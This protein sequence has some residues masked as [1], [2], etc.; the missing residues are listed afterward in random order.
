MATKDAVSCPAA[1]RSDQ[2]GEPLVNAA[3]LG[4]RH[5]DEKRE[6]RE[7]IFLARLRKHKVQRSGA[8]LGAATAEIQLIERAPEFGRH[9][10]KI[11]GSGSKAGTHSGGGPGGNERLTVPR[12]ELNP[13]TCNAPQARSGVVNRQ[14]V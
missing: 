8:R 14:R 7:H 4:F 11:W 12:I 3:A 13:A 1:R 6:Q 5:M 2:L 10:F 9:I